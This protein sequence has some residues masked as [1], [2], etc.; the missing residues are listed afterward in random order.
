M[1]LCCVTLKKQYIKKFFDL[2]IVNDDEYLNF[3]DWTSSVE[4]GST[5]WF[6]KETDNN[7][8]LEF[9]S[10]LSGEATRC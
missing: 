6:E 5:H 1:I 2:Y 10:Y 4:A 9:T 3:G 8:Y 7:G